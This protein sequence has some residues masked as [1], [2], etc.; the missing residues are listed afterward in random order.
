ML[1]HDCVGVDG[2]CAAVVLCAI[3]VDEIR[4]GDIEG[5]L[6]GGESDTIGS[7]EPI[8]YDSDVTGRRV[9]AVDLL[10]QLWFRTETLLEAVD[11]VGEPDTAVRVDDDVVGGVEGAGVVVVEE[12]V[13]F[14]GSL[15]FHVDE[16][17]GLAK[18]ALRAEDDAL[19]V[20]GAAIGH[21]VALWE[22]DLVAAEVCGREELHLRDHDRLVA[23]GHCLRG[24]VFELIRR[25]E[26]RICRWVEN[27]GFVEV[28]APWV[29]YQQL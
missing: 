10:G 29:V 25:D 21:V 3:P 15:G 18:T 14:V 4:I 12:G 7:P 17:R 5:I 16:A 6:I 28:W 20:I 1:P 8:S 9:E 27:A 22:A 24:A 11:R 19:P 13:G 2:G 26:E 23:G